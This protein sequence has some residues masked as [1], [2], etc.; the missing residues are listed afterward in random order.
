M[1]LD[2]SWTETLYIPT[3]QRALGPARNVTETW[4]PEAGKPVDQF[5]FLGKIIDDSGRAT[6]TERALN[7]D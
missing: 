2:A 4:G 5:D 6:R 7:V 1:R 3:W